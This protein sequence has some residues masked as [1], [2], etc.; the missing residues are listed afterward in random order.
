MTTDQII[1]R[2][3]ERIETELDRRYPGCLSYR[4][5]SELKDIAIAE[6]APL[7]EAVEACEASQVFITPRERIRAWDD[8]KQDAAEKITAALAQLKSIGGTDE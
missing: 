8:Y 2:L 6:L 5:A 4:E 3:A 7:R 1:E